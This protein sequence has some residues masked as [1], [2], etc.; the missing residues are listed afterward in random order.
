M[1]EQLSVSAVTKELSFTSIYAFSRAF[2]RHT[3]KTPSEYKQSLKKQYT[4]KKHSLS[5]LDYIHQALKQRPC[6][7]NNQTYMGALHGNM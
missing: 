1:L 6:E 4:C 5:F 3:G 7:N 2:K